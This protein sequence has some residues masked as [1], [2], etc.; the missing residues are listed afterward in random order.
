MKINLIAV[1]EAHCI[2]QWGYDFRPSYHKI[3]EIREF[4]PDVPILALTATATTEV[5]K[6]IQD[7]LRFKNYN[8]LSKSF[9]RKN[10]A[11]LV[12][13]TEDKQAFILK[14]IQSLKGTGI[15]YVRNRKKQRKQPSFL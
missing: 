1:D 2:S 12:R 4:F 14:I 10:I 11:Y 3:S 13:E 5:V 7:K 15:V 6:D 9:E 8:V